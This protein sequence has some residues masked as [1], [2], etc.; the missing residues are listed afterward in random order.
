VADGDGLQTSISLYHLGLTKLPTH[1]S[2]NYPL[3]PLVLG[4]VG[5]VIGMTRAANVLPVVFYFICLI[6][7]YVLANRVC[8]RMAGNG[9]LLP[10]PLDFGLLFV[11]VLGLNP[12]FFASASAPYTEGLSFALAF[13]A[14][15]LLDKEED[16]P[17]AKTRSFWFLMSGLA[18]GLAFLARSQMAIVEMAVAGAIIWRALKTRRFDWPALLAPA[19]MLSLDIIW[20]LTSYRTP[21]GQIAEIPH[22]AIWISGKGIRGYLSER[23]EGLLTSYSPFGGFSYFSLFNFATLIPLIAIAVVL[24]LLLKKRPLGMNPTSGKP[25]LPV[26]VLLTG[27]FG[28]VSLNLYHEAFFLP[29]L[30][31]YRHGLPYLFL[32]LPTAPFV[33]KHWGKA[34]TIVIVALLLLTT[35]R[36]GAQTI[37]MVTAPRITGP[38]IAEA[39][40]VAWLGAR[41]KT[42]TV[43]TTNPQILAVYSRA[44]FHWTLCSEPAQQTRTMLA[45]LPIDYVIVR[46]SE[47]SC[48]FVRGL[49]DLLVEE[50]AFGPDGERI[51]IL[52]LR[53]PAKGPNAL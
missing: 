24:W 38:S 46:D 32:M 30:F 43:L 51:H 34:G 25:L 14:L 22:F 39:Q 3:W 6:E 28:F 50:A 17:N 42:P 11:L 26:A 23:L 33:A 36:S 41:T 52:R 29:W 1:V 15:L 4:Y 7:L 31:G 35:L 53:Q 37:D 49:G 40:A 2:V 27:I 9:A 12:L 20:Y 45:Q 5:R 48:P 47:R 18:A 16:A 44:N 21:P 19:G 13:A 8:R 10:T